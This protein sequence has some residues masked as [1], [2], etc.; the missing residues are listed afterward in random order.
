MDIEIKNI[1]ESL[2]FASEEEI[3]SKQIK[4][5][6]DGFGKKI[7]LNEIDKITDALNKEFAEANK[8]YSIIKIAGGYQFSTK[9]EYSFYIGKL[10]TE[11]QK[12]K[13]SQSAIETLSV[14]AYK[15]PITRSEIEF[16]RG[17]NVDYIVNSLLE[18]ELITISGRADT[19][20]RPILYSTTKNF[21]KIL[22]LNSID[23]LPKL[24]EIN[25]ILKNENVEGITEADIELFNSMTSGQEITQQIEFSPH[26]Y[27][28]E[29]EVNTKS[30]EMNIPEVNEI[31]QIE[32]EIISEAESEDD[33]LDDR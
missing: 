30:S 23:D 27:N 10:F 31:E 16:V 2:I 17:V 20:G 28:K 14:I 29:N 15:Q 11:K 19:P 22:G 24:K 33:N 7:S 32:T 8:P 6:L 26:E 18:R 25:D 13:L 5:V 1:I 3:S 9:K 4:E 12:K 21:L